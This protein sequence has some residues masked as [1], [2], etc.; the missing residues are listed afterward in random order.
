M[1]AL[2][3][4]FAVVGLFLAVYAVA[5]LLRRHPEGAGRAR[6]SL[7]CGFILLAGVTWGLSLGW[8]LDDQW[9]GLRLG[10]ALALFLPALATLLRPSKGRALAAAVALAFAVL[11]G[12]S[13]L[14]GLRDRL[15][16][17]RPAATAQEVRTTLGELEV[18]ITDTEDYIAELRDERERLRD[19]L[20]DGDYGDFSELADDAAAYARL[21]ELAEVDRLIEDSEQWLAQ[22][23][24]NLEQLRIAARRIDRL[25]RGETAT[26][27]EVDQ[28]E[29]ERILREA[30]TPPPAKPATV[31]EHVER[32]ELRRLFESEF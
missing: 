18:R 4:A 7:G 20:A 19:D 30:R 10:F 14:P 25:A 2:S 11:L 23:R 6:T 13:A 5:F 21:E 16:P 3:L 22:A 28:A 32:E 12:V 15:S 27:V 9:A 17:S 1:N 29:I 24:R 26:G 8:Y 31:E